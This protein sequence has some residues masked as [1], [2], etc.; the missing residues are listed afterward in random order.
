MPA[1][2]PAGSLPKTSTD[3]ALRLVSAVLARDDVHLAPATLTK[4]AAGW[5]R[6]GIRA[7]EGTCA[8]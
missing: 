8:V 6:A 1:M 2:T 3:Y 4:A 7:V 5:M